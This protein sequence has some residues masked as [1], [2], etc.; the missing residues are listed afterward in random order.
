MGADNA[1]TTNESNDEKNTRTRN[2]LWLCRRAERFG[3]GCQS[4]L[5]LTLRQMPRAPTARATPKSAQKLGVK[6]LTD[7]KVQADTE[8]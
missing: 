5:G 2:C 4:E 7:A 1:A 8:G 6:D 3:C